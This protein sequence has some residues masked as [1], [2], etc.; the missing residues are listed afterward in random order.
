MSAQ[1]QENGRRNSRS[2]KLD[3]Q[4]D[5]E[6]FGKDYSDIFSCW[7][8]RQTVENQVNF[9][10]II[11]TCNGISK[12]KW[13]N[14]S[15]IECFMVALQTYLVGLILLFILLFPPAPNPEHKIEFWYSTSWII[16]IG[17]WWPWLCRLKSWM[18][19]PNLTGSLE[20]G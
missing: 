8:F 3:Y 19:W 17:P 5:Q 4:H 13:E 18:Q 9:D 6:S 16:T 20:S 10:W 11:K 14:G 12:T 1:K 7:L 15:L 2:V